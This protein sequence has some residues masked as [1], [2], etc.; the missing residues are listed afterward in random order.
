MGI[1]DTIHE[2]IDSLE[3]KDIGRALSCFTDDAS[4]FT[5][6]G[7]FRGKDNIKRYL[8]WMFDS[9]TDIQFTLE[10]VGV[11][12][13]GNKGAHQSIYSATYKGTKFRVDNIC[14]Y[15]F[16]E[17]NKI[18]N[19]WTITDRLAFAQNLATGPIERKAV[20][21]IIAKTRQGLAQQT[22]NKDETIE[23]Q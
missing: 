17:D 13:N 3:R 18:K 14:T 19:H 4:W 8:D 11:L 12:I 23:T 15:E 21:M 6:H 22:K 1:E 5:P 20:N 10:G 2:L 16:S 7:I 9:L